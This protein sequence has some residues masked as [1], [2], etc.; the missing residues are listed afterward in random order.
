MNLLESLCVLI[1]LGILATGAWIAHTL[2][3]PNNTRAALTTLY[4]LKHTRLL[5]LSDYSKLGFIGFGDMYSFARVDS[6]QL[7]H[8]FTPFYWQLQ[9][10][11]S[12]IYTK[13]SLSIYRDTPRFATTTHF[14]GRP[15]A[16]D[17]V[18]LH[19]GNTQCLSGYNNTNITGFCRDNALIDFRLHEIANIQTLALNAP[20]NCQ[21]RDSFRLYFDDFSRV[22]CGYRRHQPNALIHILVGN[23]TIFVD[24]TTGY[25]FSPLLGG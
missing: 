10:H 6:K 17:I 7:L 2:N 23:I 18:A 19:V 3:T 1:V 14:D 8:N 9:F 16:G 13:N 11:I 25:A 21:E 5:A 12:G 22:L 15:L 4:A 20:A 24:P